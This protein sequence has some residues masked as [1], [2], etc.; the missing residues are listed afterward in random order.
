M[1]HDACKMLFPKF[2]STARL[3]DHVA[4]EQMQFDRFAGKY[5]KRFGEI[6]AP[7]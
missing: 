3:D 2:G 6:R 7:N 1:S 4:I 5:W